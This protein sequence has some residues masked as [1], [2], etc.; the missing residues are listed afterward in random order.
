VWRF[1]GTVTT[2]PPGGTRYY[3]ISPAGPRTGCT[4]DPG[5]IPN[6]RGGIRCFH[7][8]HDETRGAGTGAFRVVKVWRC[9]C[10]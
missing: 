3:L 8:R 4:P 6:G 10:R 9:L 1:V 2:V 5:F 7:L